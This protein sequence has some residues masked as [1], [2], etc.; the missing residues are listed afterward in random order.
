MITPGQ[1]L[2]NPVTG[3]R[4]TFTETA[5]IERRRA[6]RLRLR[7]APRR[8]GPDPARPPDPDRALR[9]RRRP[10]ALPRRPAHG[11][12]RARATSSRWQPGVM[13]SFAN[14]GDEEARLRVEVRPGAADGGDVRRGRRDGPG[15]ADDAPRPAAQPAR[16][17]DARAPVRPGGARAVPERRRAAAAARAARRCRPATRA[18]RAWPPWR[19]G[20][21]ASASSAEDGATVAMHGALDVLTLVTALGCGLS[22][23]VF[24]AFSA[25]VMDGLRP[26]RGARGDRGDAVDQP[27]RADARVPAR[28]ARDRRR[29]AVVARGVDRGCRAATGGRS[30]RSRPR[31]STSAGASRSPSRAMSR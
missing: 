23:G 12:R 17:R 10:D 13:H 6:A 27:P 21:R 4:F 11:H 29:C 20:S 24:F 18:A 30:S 28:V 3:E 8:R 9:G 31:R 5:A 15:R 2:E 22:A 14:A 26:G 16:P 25:F 7:A 1:T 19:A